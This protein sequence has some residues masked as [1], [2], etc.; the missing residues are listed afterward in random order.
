MKLIKI[1]PRGFCSGVVNAWKQVEETILNNPNKII[2]MLGLFVH[3]EEMI[4]RI[5]AKNLIILDDTNTSRY[6]LVKKIKNAKNS[7]LILS[8]HGTDQKTINLAKRK[9]MQIVDTTCEYVY[10]TH[11]FINDSLK[12]NK[13]VIYIGRKNHP[14][15]NAT[16][17]ISKKILFIYQL[18]QIKKMK[19]F[20]N[21]DIVV[22]NQTTLSKIDLQ[23]Y[24]NLIK[25]Y[26]K[27][28]YIKN[29][30]CNA[31]IDRQNAIL[32]LKENPN[33]LI[34]IG[35]N[36]SNNSLQLLKMGKFKK[37]EQ[38]YLINSIDEIKKIKIRE[39]DVIAITSGAST[40][41]WLTNEIINYLESI[42]WN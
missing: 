39:D 29:D 31:T 8:A 41:T 42:E 20:F 17:K 22:T 1:T 3:N 40:P 27:N 35:S 37:I 9:K 2:Y 32:N 28:Y 7:I 14:E 11:K 26:F 6:N 12:Q 16:I 24:Y 15:S 23:E 21:K 38:N 30:L 19:K 18:D 10:N 34:V 33:I 4:K 13:V 25:F 36:R 5:I